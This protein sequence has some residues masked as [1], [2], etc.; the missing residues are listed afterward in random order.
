MYGFLVVTKQYVCS[1][2]KYII[3]SYFNNYNKL[4]YLYYRLS[5]YDQLLFLVFKVDFEEITASLEPHN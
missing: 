3:V 4:F 1:C 2:A 5:G